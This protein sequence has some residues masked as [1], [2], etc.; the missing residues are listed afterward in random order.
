MKTL[1]ITA[2]ICSVMGIISLLR[3]ILEFAALTD[4][5]QGVEPNLEA[6]WRVVKYSFL[7]LTV[8]HFSVFAMLF[9]LFRSLKRERS[10][11]DNFNPLYETH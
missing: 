9:M 10:K 1:R 2:G 11:P 8:F 3:L 7:P 5:G 4:I 6:E